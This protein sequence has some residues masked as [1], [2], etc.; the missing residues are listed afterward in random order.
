MVL[1]PA[2]A[3]STRDSPRATVRSLDTWRV[4]QGLIGVG[5]YMKGEIE[6]EGNLLSTQPACPGLC[7]NPC[8]SSKPA[9]APCRPGRQAVLPKVTVHGLGGGVLLLGTR[10]EERE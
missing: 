9:K 7:A 6:G 5:K 4:I 8:A 2:T 3:W 10:A 1:T